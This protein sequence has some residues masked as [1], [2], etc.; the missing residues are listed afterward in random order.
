MDSP[1]PH[2]AGE[3]LAKAEGLAL[4]QARTEKVGLQRFLFR[5]NVPGVVSP[6]CP[7]GRGDQ[8]AAYLFTKCTDVRSRGLRAFAYATEKR[9]IQGL[10]HHD[11]A[12]D[13]A[14]G[15]TQSGWLPQFRVFNSLHRAGLAAEDDS[16][17]WACRPSPQPTR[18]RT[19]ALAM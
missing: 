3:K 9:R 10:S 14:R 4:C 8:I 15:L 1:S 7:C 6:A 12:P 18:R 2:S 11:T 5:C 13:M 16:Y 17:A 19:R